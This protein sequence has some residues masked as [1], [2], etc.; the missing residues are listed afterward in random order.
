MME[1]AGKRILI[2][3]ENLPL[4]FDRRVWQE[5]KTLNDY[6]YKVS[7]ICPMGEGYEKAYEEID[8]IAIYRHPLPLEANGTAGYLLEYSAAL[9][10]EFRLS[11]KVFRERGFDVI[12]ACNPPDN[13]FIVGLFWK[14]FFGK[15]F[16]FDHHDIN[17]EL[18]IAKFGKKNLFYRIMLL[19]ERIDFYD[20]RPFYCYQ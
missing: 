4:P 15:R 13:I 19:W 9:W 2:I 10:G 12:Q 5:A 14:L 8:G 20:S 7:I 3:V 18:Y 11:L 17:P 1:S 16:V 6:G